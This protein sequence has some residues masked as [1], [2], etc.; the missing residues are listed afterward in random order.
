M[1]GWGIRV[2][3]RRSVLCYYLTDNAEDWLQSNA[4]Q[5]T[6]TGHVNACKLQF[7]SISQISLKYTKAIIYMIT[8]IE[9]NEIK[10]I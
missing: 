6:R 1:A 5:E 9:S 8:K 10:M 2:F 4:C 3:G 7:K